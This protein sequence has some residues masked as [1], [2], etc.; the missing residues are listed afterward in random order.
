MQL[1]LIRSKNKFRKPDPTHFRNILNNIRVRVGKLT[2]F[3]E[4]QVHHATILEYNDTCGAHEHYE[5]F[6][7][8]LKSTY[9]DELAR[10][11]SC[12]MATHVYPEPKHPTVTPNRN[13]PFT[14]I[15]P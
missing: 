1:E 8:K 3:A 9:E 11:L 12:S 14:Q 2:C 13:P 4:L 7:S 15:R 6:R 10:C 5:Y